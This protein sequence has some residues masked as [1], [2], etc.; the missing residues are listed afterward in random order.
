M[1]VDP[2]W[3]SGEATALRIAPAND[4]STAEVVT[5]G[6]AVPVWLAA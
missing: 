2:T 1:D 3:S 6:V 5:T 4:I